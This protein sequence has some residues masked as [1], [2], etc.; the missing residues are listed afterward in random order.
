MS[1]IRPLQFLGYS[2]LTGLLWAS[3]VTIVGYFIGK[4]LDLKTEVFEQN[5][6]FIIAG[7]ASFGM[8]V[9]YAV[10]RFTEKELD[11]PAA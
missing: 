9:G 3:T 5:I 7:F 2:V 8:L 1:G 10:K 6:F 11:T 4:F